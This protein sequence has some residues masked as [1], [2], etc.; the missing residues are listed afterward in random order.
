[1]VKK[2][3]CAYTRKRKVTRKLWN[4]ILT[5]LSYA[6]F[7]FLL[8]RQSENCSMKIYFYFHLRCF[9]LFIII[10]CYCSLGFFLVFLCLNGAKTFPARKKEKSKCSRIIHVLEIIETKNFH[11]NNTQLTAERRQH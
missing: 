2:G 6:F 4:F 8:L 10:L 9:P 1:M 11:F 3:E 7:V 5:L